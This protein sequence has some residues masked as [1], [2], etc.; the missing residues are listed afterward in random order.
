MFS[1]H[2]TSM[3]HFVWNAFKFVVVM[4]EIVNNFALQ[5]ALILT[6]SMCLRIKHSSGKMI[7]VSTE[8][9]VLFFHHDGAKTGCSILL[10][11]SSHLYFYKYPP[12]RAQ[13]LSLQEGL[14]YSNGLNMMV[15]CISEEHIL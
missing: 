15:S 13:G 2:F 14:C 12:G 9:L 6:N 3:H 4:R 10:R 11:M 1:F 7:S 8:F 5:G